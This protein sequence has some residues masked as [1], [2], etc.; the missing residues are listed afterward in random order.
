MDG[1]EIG[2][3]DVARMI[4]RGGEV[5]ADPRPLR[6]DFVPETALHRGSE[7]RE[8][9]AF[10]DPQNP[11]D[12]AV[13][14]SPG[15][16]KTTVARVVAVGM[17]ERGIE[18]FYVSATGSTEYELLKRVALR[19][20]DRETLARSKSAAWSA[21]S[22]SAR[23]SAC[24]VLDN[25]KWSG[26]LPG[27]LSKLG[28]ETEISVISLSRDAIVSPESGH[29]PHRVEL[30]GYTQGEI[31]DILRYHAIQLG[32]FSEGVVREEELAL[33]A[34]LTFADFNG[35][36]AKGIE[37]LRRA[38]SLLVEGGGEDPELTSDHIY[39]AIDDMRLS[40]SGADDVDDTI[41]LVLAAL[42]GSCEMSRLLRICGLLG[43]DGLYIPSR[44]TVWR[45]LHKLASR[46]ALSISE[47]RGRSKSKV[48][49]LRGS[50]KQS[51]ARVA[52]R[53]GRDY[54]EAVVARVEGIVK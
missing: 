38:G 9:A 11:F 47:S 34:N 29:I 46:R 24:L 49:K 37:L 30:S 15:S 19:L 10:V 12:I 54:A 48:V 4:G 41:P 18:V 16:G 6:R 31:L 33:C 27:V 43:D 21:I 26:F 14:G 44:S 3:G 8:I 36:C 50:P 23:S 51:I 5:F 45:H 35:D 1:K 53:R 39:T 13:T 32:A 20:T 17:E 40:G 7:I 52:R 42:G 25:V 28:E 2:A 22:E